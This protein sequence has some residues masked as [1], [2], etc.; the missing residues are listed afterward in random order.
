MNQPKEL[1]LVN[2]DNPN[3]NK[4]IQRSPAN[5]EATIRIKNLHKNFGS[6]YAVRGVNLNVYKGEIT[7]LL[8]HNGA[9][10]TTMLDILTGE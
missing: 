3:V 7:V 6:T 8:G 4:F 5:L 1:E 9:G 2:P 10:K